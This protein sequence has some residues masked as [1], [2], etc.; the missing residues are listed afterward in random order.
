M[1]VRDFVIIFVADR[2]NMR[3]QILDQ[4]GRFVAQWTQFGRSSG[5]ALR[6]DDLRRR[7]R[8][9][10]RRPAPGMEALHPRRQPE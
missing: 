2:G 7:L 5:V 6:R 9:R 4:D 10:R 3:I 8:I 1:P